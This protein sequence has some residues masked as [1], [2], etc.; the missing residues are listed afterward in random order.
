[1]LTSL[2]SKSKDVIESKT[3]G[4]VTWKQKGSVWQSIEQEFQALTGCH[5]ETKTQRDKY[6]N[7]KKKTK[8]KFATNKT[9]IIK[10]G[11]GSCQFQ[12]FDLVD[13]QIQDIM[14]PQLEGLTNNYDD[15]CSDQDEVVSEHVP[16]ANNCDDSEVVFNNG[17][18]SSYTPQQLKRPKTTKL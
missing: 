8:S 7:S 13:T 17:K 9:N 1:M 3:S 14:G 12:A 11:G 16:Y 10:T 2:V 15:E 5:R 18:W 6:F 4:T